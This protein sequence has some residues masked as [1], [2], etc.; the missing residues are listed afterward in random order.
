M[1]KVD[2][3]AV[4]VIVILVDGPVAVK[5]RVAVVGWATVV[6]ASTVD[7]VISKA[8]IVHEPPVMPLTPPPAVRRNYK[9][10]QRELVFCVVGP[11]FELRTPI[12]RLAPSTDVVEHYAQQGCECPISHKKCF[13]ALSLVADALKAFCSLPIA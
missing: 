5:L 10:G 4:E 9:S 6:A 8:E 13:G 3:A 1:V 7:E 2:V 11:C 12:R